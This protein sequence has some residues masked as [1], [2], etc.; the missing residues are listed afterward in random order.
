MIWSATGVYRQLNFGATKRCDQMTLHARGVSVEECKEI[1]TG[2][3]TCNFISYYPEQQWCYTSQQCD[4]VP[5]QA[6]IYMHVERNDSIPTNA[7]ATAK[8]SPAFCRNRG[9]DYNIV[10]G[11][12]EQCAQFCAD[13]PNCD[14]F[15]RCSHWGNDQCV[16][17]AQSNPDEVS[18][19]TCTIYEVE[20]PSLSPT[21]FSSTSIPTMSPVSES[22]STYP[23]T[24][25][26]SHM[27]NIHHYDLDDVRAS[28]DILQFMIYSLEDLNPEQREDLLRDTRA[29]LSNLEQNI[30]N[31]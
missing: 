23:L 10:T 26:P 6:N 24:E 14:Q 1:C 16:K 4:I 12:P 31:L 30:S 21:A 8:D 19:E 28:I 22:L 2:I 27:S 11:T 17:C 15:Y 9:D 29:I 20:I 3:E 7:V 25:M 13:D 5:C 18:Y